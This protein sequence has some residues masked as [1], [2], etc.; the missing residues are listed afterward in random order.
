MY[1]GDNRRSLQRGFGEY[2]R[3]EKLRRGISVVLFSAL[4]WALISAAPSCA[5]PKKNARPIALSAT[6]RASC[7]DCSQAGCNGPKDNCCGNGKCEAGETCS[8][9]ECDCGGCGCQHC[10]STGPCACAQGFTCVMGN[11]VVGGGGNRVGCAKLAS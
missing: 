1:A 9:C 8:T 2:M 7:Q 3:I 6:A 5:G 10:D 11:C 4:T